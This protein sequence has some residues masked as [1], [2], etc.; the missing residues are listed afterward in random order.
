MF[1]KIRIT[2]ST[3]S[4]L[5]KI[6][7]LFFLSV[8]LWRV[9]SRLHQF[10]RLEWCQLPHKVWDQVHP[11]QTQKNASSFNSNSFYSY[12]LTSASGGSKQMV[13]CDNVTFLIAVPWR[14]SST[15]WH[16]ARLENPARVSQ[17]FYLLDVCGPIFVKDLRFSPSGNSL[18]L[19]VGSYLR[20]FM[21]A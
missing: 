3:S 13:K 10:N 4:W 15:I 12:T 6:I 2:F 8:S 21:Q 16:I 5:L 18:V 7:F 9:N 20:L 17:A 14:M 11:Q 1:Q 19:S